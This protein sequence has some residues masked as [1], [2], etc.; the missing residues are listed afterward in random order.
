MACRFRQPLRQLTKGPGTC[1]QPVIS[2]LSFCRAVGLLPLCANS[3]PGEEG[4]C[5]SFPTGDLPHWA[6]SGLLGDWDRAVQSREE[7]GRGVGIGVGI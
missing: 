1:A 7:I 3:E 6:N 2:V 4:V 5:F